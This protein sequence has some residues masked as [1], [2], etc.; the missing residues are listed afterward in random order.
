MIGR[1]N[2][3]IVAAAYKTPGDSP[4]PCSEL[5]SH[6]NMLVLGKNCFVFDSVHGPTVD[7]SPFDPHLV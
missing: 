5:Y 3:S 4:D 6:D 7:V 1:I 2:Y